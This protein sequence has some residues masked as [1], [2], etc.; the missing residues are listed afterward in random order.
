M[1]GLSTLDGSLGQ[2]HNEDKEMDLLH[3]LIN[4]HSSQSQVPFV[5][6]LLYFIYLFYLFFIWRG[7]AS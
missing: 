2:Y 4:S 3:S 1:I 5:M 6:M 7:S